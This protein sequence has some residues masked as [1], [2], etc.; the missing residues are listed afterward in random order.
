[1]PTT[2]LFVRSA[3]TLALLLMPALSSF[4]E[5][6]L[7]PSPPPPGADEAPAHGDDDGSAGPTTSPS[8]SPHVVAK[9]RLALKVEAAGTFLPTAPLEVRVRPSAYNGDLTIVAAA[10][11]GAAVKKGDTI[12]Q[13]DP[14]DLNRDLD[15]A[16]NDLVA[17]RAALTKAE[18]DVEMGA[19]A[20]ALALKVSENSARK[21]A[22]D[23]KWWD[24]LTGPH[25]LEQSE[26]GLRQTRA[27]MED[28]QDELEQ[29]K[30]MYKTE[31]LTGATADIVLKRAVRQYEIAKINVKLQEAQAR[32]TREYDQPQSRLP[33][34][35]AVE[36]TGNSL[37]QLR[38]TQA[39]AKVTRETA[40]KTAQLGLAAAEKRVADLEKD[41]AQL[42]VQ[43]PADGV[44][45]YGQ[46]GEGSLTPTD[47]K[48]LRPGEKLAPGG[49]VMVLFTPGSLRL[50]FDLPESKLAWVKPGM[51][52]KV[53]PLAWPEL[54]YDGTA[55]APPV[56]CKSAGPGEQVFPMSIELIGIDPKILPGM[57][58]SVKIDAGQGEE[59]VL[60]PAPAV[61][62]GKVRVRTKDG[63]EEEREVVTGRADGESIEIRQGLTAGE[64][65]LL[66]AKS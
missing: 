7:L 12:L 16:R 19:K 52:A 28:Q 31:D 53:T 10:P 13:I 35:F 33:L 61:K 5:E 44:V 46:V 50:G 34:E 63:K 66:G 29:L 64:E 40:L 51:R 58:A 36:Q 18:A 27:Y 24:E 17:A 57:K 11:N 6:G 1:M 4:A 8:P 62:D 23:L 22:A 60:V 65:I 38:I 42:T 30:A 21:A 55:A 48:S 41:L 54:T 32:K 26:L 9:G 39:H 20:D 45:L 49:T 14:A 2:R 47:P 43:A 25:M 56:L 59:V 15:G 3:V 37:A